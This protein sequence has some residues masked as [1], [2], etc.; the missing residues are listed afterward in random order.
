MDTVYTRKQK[1]CG[2]LFAFENSAYIEKGT[3]EYIGGVNVKVHSLVYENNQQSCGLK[4]DGLNAGLDLN[5]EE[6][7]GGHTIEFVGST[8]N[9][10]GL[11]VDGTTAWVDQGTDE[12]IGSH[13]VKVVNVQKDKCGFIVDGTNVWIDK[14][15]DE[16]I[17]NVNVLLHSTLVPKSR[18]MQPSCGLLFVYS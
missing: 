6:I 9:A 4:V 16:I 14:G 17:D 8:E 18:R 3:V 15:T 5:T 2:L 1:S 13:K 12:N 11:I 7:V 10:C